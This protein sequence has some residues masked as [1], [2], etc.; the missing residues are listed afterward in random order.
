VGKD[1]ETRD[2]EVQ[3]ERK[4]T[5]ADTITF[6]VLTEVREALGLEAKR[7]GA[8]HG[9]KAR[10]TRNHLRPLDR[11]DIAHWVLVDYLNQAPE[12][13]EARALKGLKDM[14]ARSGEDLTQFDLGLPKIRRAP[15]PGSR[16]GTG[17]DFRRGGQPPRRA[18][19]SGTDG[20]RPD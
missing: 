17:S 6:K 1:D 11:G 18:K 7:L 14:L 8:A 2:Q 4:L 12:E 3:G 9:L 13:R 16:E 5:K 10:S 15:M 19:G 20:H